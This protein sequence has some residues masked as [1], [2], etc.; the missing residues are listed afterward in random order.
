MQVIVGRVEPGA[1]FAHNEKPVPFPVPEALSLKPSAG[2]PASPHFS[3]VVRLWWTGNEPWLSCG[4]AYRACGQNMGR[5]NCCQEGSKEAAGEEGLLLWLQVSLVHLEQ[6]ADVSGV[7][8]LQC[9]NILFPLW[10]LASV[11][12]VVRPEHDRTA[13]LP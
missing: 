10:A 12:A 4:S 11:E 8:S 2:I 13:I 9:S 5:E 7:R 3:P 1:F 6:F